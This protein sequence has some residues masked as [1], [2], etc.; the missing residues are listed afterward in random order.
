MR[1]TKP[2]ETASQK[3]S[4][5]ALGRYP[6]CKP[7]S[8]WKGVQEILDKPFL[9]L[10]FVHVAWKWVSPSFPQQISARL[11]ANNGNKW[12]YVVPLQEK[13]LVWKG[14]RTVSGTRLV[15]KCLK[16]CEAQ[17]SSS[18]FPCAIWRSH[19]AKGRRQGDSRPKGAGTKMLRQSDGSRQPPFHRN[20][21]GW[22]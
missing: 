17:L 6:C 16:C 18:E 22:T 7:S 20:F 12:K 21:V 2:S 11:L 4:F 9:G 19:W 13:Y 8:K 5:A 10:S 3:T 15:L 14:F 1:F